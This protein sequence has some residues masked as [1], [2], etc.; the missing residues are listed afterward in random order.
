MERLRENRIKQLA[1]YS[2]NLQ[3]AEETWV[4]VLVFKLKDLGILKYYIY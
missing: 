1:E 2:V 3:K 4:T